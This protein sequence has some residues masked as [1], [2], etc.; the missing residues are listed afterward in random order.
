MNLVAHRRIWMVAALMALTASSNGSTL[1]YVPQADV[2]TG[3]TNYSWWGAGNWFNLDGSG[4][5]KVPG[6]ADSAIITSLVDA[7]GKG[8]RVVNL[9]LTNNAV[10]TNGTFSVLN[11]QMLS[12]SSF[13]NAYVNIL[14]TL[15]V[16]GTNC[17]LSGTIMNVLSIANGTFAEFR[18]AFAA[19]YVPSKN[20]RS[21]QVLAE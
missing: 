14:T 13:H 10:V 16:G 5:G 11:L 1:V 9:L 2:I 8:I 6:T 12:A 17:L 15:S 21:R 19:G 4:A 20:L 3:T 18:R 7:T